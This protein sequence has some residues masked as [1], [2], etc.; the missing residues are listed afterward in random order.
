M[1]TR[2]MRRE[3]EAFGGLDIR[4]LGVFVNIQCTAHSVFGSSV[5]I[6]SVNQKVVRKKKKTQKD[7][8]DFCI[9]FCP[10]LCF[11]L[12]DVEVWGYQI[13]IFKTFDIG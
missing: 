10:S 8:Y 9:L 4:A 3:W 6:L 2:N 1:N 13:F 12:D 11:S 5:C 7:N